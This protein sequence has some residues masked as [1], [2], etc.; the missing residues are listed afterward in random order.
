MGGRLL[1]RTAAVVGCDPESA[2]EEGEGKGHYGRGYIAQQTQGLACSPVGEG[3]PDPGYREQCWGRGEG[4]LAVPNNAG[5][6]GKE[7]RE[8]WRGRRSTTVRGRG[9]RKKVPRSRKIFHPYIYPRRV[10]DSI[11]P[12]SYFS[13]EEVLIFNNKMKAFQ[14][15]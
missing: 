5:A 8:R 1:L 12:S 7:D 13:S 3:R 4:T 9:R 15:F 11:V 14:L 10:N 6:E 2:R